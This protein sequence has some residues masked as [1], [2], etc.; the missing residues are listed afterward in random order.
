M[1]EVHNDN[2]NKTIE[3]FLTEDDVVVEFPKKKKR[4]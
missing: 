1:E 4:I 3:D 2:E